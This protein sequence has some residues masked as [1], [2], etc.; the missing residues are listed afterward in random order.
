MGIFSYRCVHP[1]A[2]SWLSQ[3]LPLPAPSKP[4]PKS[5]GEWQG[6]LRPTLLT[7]RS[8]FICPHVG[9]SDTSPPSPQE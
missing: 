6:A 5:P 8:I 3:L 7:P 9:R 2:S 4:L 1:R